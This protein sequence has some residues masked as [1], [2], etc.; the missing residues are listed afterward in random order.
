MLDILIMH[1]YSGTGGSGAPELLLMQ[2]KDLVSQLRQVLGANVP[3]LS[4][5]FTCFHKPVA[6]ID[7]SPQEAA[8]S[9]D[10]SRVVG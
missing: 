5:L 4:H 9:T 2:R 10:L 6:V 3:S 1:A 8:A 7:W